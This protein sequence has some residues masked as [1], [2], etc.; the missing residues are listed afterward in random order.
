MART[1]QGGSIVGF[2][3]IGAVLVLGSAGLLYFVSHRDVSS[4]KTPEVSVPATTKTDE[5][6]SDEKKPETPTNSESDTNK[7]TTNSAPTNETQS[8]PTAN[9]NTSTVEQIP[10]TGP[11]DTFVQ[12]L[13]VG[14]LA[15]VG[16]AFVRSY[17]H[18][19]TL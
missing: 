5:K 11:A 9:S 16:V 7:D 6:T 10:Q 19:S 15:G 8:Q 4:V 12:I 3:I 13:V 14:L 1:N 17:K 2:V 18:R